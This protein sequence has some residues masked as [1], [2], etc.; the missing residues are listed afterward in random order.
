[1]KKPISKLL[2]GALLV[3]SG[4]QQAQAW[5]TLEKPVAEDGRAKV[6]LRWT[7]DQKTFTVYRDDVEIAKDVPAHEYID[8]GAKPGTTVYYQ[9]KD[10]A[11]QWS[12]KLSVWV[13]NRNTGMKIMSIDREY[14][15]SLTQLMNGYTHNDNYSLSKRIGDGN[16]NIT[17]P[18]W[19]NKE[20]F[21]TEDDWA[22]L[23]YNGSHDKGNGQSKYYNYVIDGNRY[24]WLTDLTHFKSDDD[25]LNTSDDW[26][27][28][29][30]Y[31]WA[32]FGVSWRE[33]NINRNV[34]GKSSADQFT[35]IGRYANAVN[36]KDVPE[37]CWYIACREGTSEHV[38]NGTVEQG[39]H[40]K[41]G[42][43]CVWAADRTD[44]MPYQG[45]PMFLSYGLN[46]HDKY[47][48][49]DDGSPNNAAGGCGFDNDNSYGIAMSEN[50][51]SW[52]HRAGSD[53]YNNPL[54][55]VIM[56][57]SA[58]TGSHHIF[59]P[60]VGPYVNEGA[61]NQVHNYSKY[62]KEWTKYFSLKQIG[63]YPVKQ[64]NL[65]NVKGNLFSVGNATGDMS[66]GYIW[67][68]SNVENG[69]ITL[70]REYVQDFANTE[71]RFAAYK[72]SGMPVN[73]GTN[74]VI[75]MA[76]NGRQ[77]VFF[78]VSHNNTGEPHLYY[79]SESQN[80]PVTAKEGKTYSASQLTSYNLGPQFTNC[81]GGCTFEYE[82]AKYLV[83]A[84][85]RPQGIEGYD[86][87]KHV[88][89]F[90]VF[91]I[92]ENTN[93]GPDLIPVANY[94]TSDEKF[95]L[96]NKKIKTKEGKYKDNVIRMFI[97]ARTRAARTK[98]GKTVPAHVEIFTYVPGRVI[99]M[100]NFRGNVVSDSKPTIAIKPN[101]TN[102][103]VDQH[104]KL[105][106]TGTDNVAIS[107]LKP[108]YS[109]LT[110]YKVSTS[111]TPAKTGDY[112]FA[113]DEN[114]N[115]AF[116]TAKS[117]YEGKISRIN[118]NSNQWE[119]VGDS[120]APTDN[121][122]TS[123]EI[124][125]DTEV[126]Y[127]TR[128]RFTRKKAGE[129]EVVWGNT[130]ESTTNLS[131]KPEPVTGLTVKHYVSSNNSGIHRYDI[132]FKAPNEVK[133][134]DGTVIPVTR[135]EISRGEE[136]GTVTVN[137]VTIY[138]N[139]SKNGLKGRS[140]DLAFVT[141]GDQIVDYKTEQWGVYKY[142]YAK[143][144]DVNAQTRAG[145]PD[146]YVSI[147]GNYNFDTMPRTATQVMNLK[148]DGQDAVVVLVTKDANA[149]NQKFFVRAVY[150]TDNWNGKEDENGKSS[151]DAVSKYADAIAT[152]QYGGTT[153]VVEIEAADNNGEDE[154][155]TLQGIR[156][157]AD[158]LTPGFYIRKNA[159]GAE[160]ILVY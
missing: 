75:P 62:H 124:F 117:G 21:S 24:I 121:V 19:K 116:A 56:H 50:G 113:T 76:G 145:N 134:S 106:H 20:D 147:P 84:R 119:F 59:F 43:L 30:R 12:A 42:V 85:R 140:D 65:P 95:C 92:K 11:D 57:T 158:Q 39:T 71:G 112:V 25:I 67:T 93:G 97:G 26:Y 152:P 1:M 81:I 70:R 125:L 17:D 139:A 31:P 138:R 153:E 156:V 27:A 146:K 118:P 128:P 8:Y 5:V 102:V 142:N 87:I 63:T 120:N 159:K 79:L 22:F 52:M 68:A 107:G 3:L 58:V 18:G 131:Y 77:D 123:K 149:A 74:Y 29:A 100:Y 2:A 98:N 13:A 16:A 144:N 47:Q 80:L 127:E 60:A 133:A 36:G 55:K 32:A 72:I 99:S 89:D 49:N 78:Q 108:D 96:A 28:A 155:Y 157:N 115:S 160:K 61:N 137:G 148:G 136:G 35:K 114:K 111:H 82:G 141:I 132:Y 53:S 94:N 6:Y 88:G 45:A 37:E 14:E 44:Y 154:Y 135:Y 90:T 110:H 33:M 150:G 69:N 129:E 103:G 105:N 9:I 122:S 15:T 4:A 86:A 38:V 40:L 126:K 143:V 46:Y 10:A 64:C 104:N 91:L 66:Y 23:K 151:T 130:S 41:Y 101:V 83:L 7:S 54:T 34:T 48:I 73:C 109:H 51:R